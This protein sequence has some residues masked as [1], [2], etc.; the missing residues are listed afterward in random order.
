MGTDPSSENEVQSVVN[1]LQRNKSSHPKFHVYFNLHAYGRF[2]LL[3]WT[4]TAFEKISRYDD[5]LKRSNRI[6]S[7]M[8]QTYSVGQ[9]SLLLYPCS[10][11]SIDFAATIMPHAMTFELSPLYNGLPLCPE[12][13]ATLEN[14]C[15]IGF[16]IG[17]EVIEIDGSVI[18]NAMVEYLYSIVQDRFL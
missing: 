13:N 16:M 11:T 5:L 15:T 9:A 10:G 17:P 1:F 4:Y 14:N 18:F 2:W 12:K 3:P 8:N 7:N 6:A